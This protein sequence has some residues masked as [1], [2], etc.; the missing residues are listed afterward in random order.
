[1]KLFDFT[2][3]KENNIFQYI[4]I[5]VVIVFIIYM[6]LK[7]ANTQMK[8]VEGLVGGN[9]NQ[10]PRSFMDLVASGDDVS[11]KTAIEKMKDTLLLDKY[12]SSYEDVIID[13]E[14]IINQNLLYHTLSFASAVDEKTGLIKFSD[15]GEPN[16][17]SLQTLQQ[18]NEL[19]TYKENLNAT[20][21][22]ID[23]K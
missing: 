9:T 19:Y 7:L 20:M 17:I 23:G 5:L 3:F 21:S 10:T 4:G 2:E 16:T 12:R 8:I 14:D 22:Y 6:F 15:K 11:L 1:M 13:L 18:I